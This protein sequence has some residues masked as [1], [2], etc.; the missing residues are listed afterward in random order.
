MPPEGQ[1]SSRARCGRRAP[2]VTGP[3]RITIRVR[4]G[5]ARTRVGGTWG[6]GSTGGP[7]QILCVWVHQRAVGGKA[8]EAA[9]GALAGALGVPR[10][11]LRL[12]TGERARVKIVEVG[13][14]PAGLAER[15]ADLR[16]RPGA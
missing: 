11:S 16:A 7:G 5:A 4:P 3:L 14:P 12:V 13:D 2:S 8:T 1:P 10:R 6:T 9:L 15:V